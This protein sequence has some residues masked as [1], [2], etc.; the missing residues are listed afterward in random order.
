MKTE[1]GDDMNLELFGTHPKYL[2]RHSGPDTSVES[3]YSVDSTKLEKMVY[4]VICSF[5]NGCISDDV[6]R[7]LSHLPYSSVTAR[8][9]ALL[10]KGLIIDTGERRKGSSGKNQR[11]LRRKP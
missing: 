4:D 7:I 3:A 9:R 6:R 11:V 2:H 1:K 5:D 10:D 8:Y